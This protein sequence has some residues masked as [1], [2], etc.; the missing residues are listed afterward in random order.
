LS[1]GWDNDLCETVISRHN[2]NRYIT[3]VV[4]RPG[5]RGDLCFSSQGG[6]PNTAKLEIVIVRYDNEDWPRVHSDMNAQVAREQQSQPEFG[7][8]FFCTNKIKLLLF[9]DSW[10]ILL[11]LVI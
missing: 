3:G 8:L 10:Y 9:V 6:L 2:E 1:T 11:I 7:W 5:H 4:P